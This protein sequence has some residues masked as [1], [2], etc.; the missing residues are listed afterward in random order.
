MIEEFKDEFSFLSNFATCHIVYEGIEFSSVEAAYQAAKCKY[1]FEKKEFANLTAS[2]AKRKS[3]RIVVREDWEDIK[4]EVME[5]LLIQKFN[6]EPFKTKLLETKNHIIQEGN[7]W[8]D[9]FW[10]VDL[11]TKIGKTHLG[12]LLMK[13][14]DSL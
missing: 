11:K 1:D 7:N 8:G 10:G 3:K 13:I 4:I 5:K 2:K 9:V 12:V 14:R 6:Q